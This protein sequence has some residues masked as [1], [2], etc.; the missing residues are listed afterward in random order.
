[1]GLGLV[2]LGVRG[3]YGV[4]F[5]EHEIRGNQCKHNK[6]SKRLVLR[7]QV[8]LGSKLPCSKFVGDGAKSVLTRICGTDCK[9]WAKNL[10]HFH[11][12]VKTTAPSTLEL[13]Q[14]FAGTPTIY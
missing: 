11:R 3:F 5:R 4:V 2:G 9:D 10:D 8:L 14:C 6:L 7:T 1:M 13:R 12:H